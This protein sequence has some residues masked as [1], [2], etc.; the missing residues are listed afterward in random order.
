VEEDFEID[1]CELLRPIRLPAVEYFR[2][3][4][5]LEVLVI[6]EYLYLMDYIFTVT[7]PVF[8]RVYNYEKLFIVDLI[9]DFGW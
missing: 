7:P 8:E 5:V 1:T 9:V 2:C 4:K 6:G 3:C